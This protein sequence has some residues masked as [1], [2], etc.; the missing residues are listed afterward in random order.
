MKDIGVV[1]LLM[2]LGP[3]LLFMGI[4]SVRRRWWQDSVPLA[5][6][7]IDRA[8]GIDPPPRNRWDR[9]FARVQAWLYILLGFFF[10]LCLAAVL[11]S[12]LSE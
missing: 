11:F 7:L 6:F 10:T 1:L 2:L 8:A 9:G 4:V 5:E 3:G 12:L